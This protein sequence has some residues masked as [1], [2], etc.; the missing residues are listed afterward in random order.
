MSCR[1]ILL[2]ALA[3]H[4]IPG[5]SQAVRNR[6]QQKLCESPGDLQ[7]LEAAGQVGSHGHDIITHDDDSCHF[8]PP[9]LG[10]SRTHTHVGDVSN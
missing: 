7:S 5:A 4:Y 8:F 10:D 2:L 6:G 9:F 1:Y 3:L